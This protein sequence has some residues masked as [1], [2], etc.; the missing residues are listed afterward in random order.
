MHVSMSHRR[1]LTQPKYESKVDVNESP[2]GI[3]HD[4]SVVPCNRIVEIVQV[5]R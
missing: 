5:S 3:D 2:C 1:L 4:V